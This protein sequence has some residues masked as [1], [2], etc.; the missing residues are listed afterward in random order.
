MSSN[1]RRT[2]WSLEDY[3][4]LNSIELCTPLAGHRGI[5]CEI[6]QKGPSLSQNNEIG[7]G[8]WLSPQYY[9]PSPGSSEFKYSVIKERN[10]NGGYYDLHGKL[11]GFSGND[12]LQSLCYCFQEQSDW[13]SSESR[14]S[15]S[16]G[17]EFSDSIEFVEERVPDFTESGR[18]LG[19]SQYCWSDSS[20]E[21]ERNRLDIEEGTYIDEKE[22]G[23][24]WLNEKL[25]SMF[26][27]PNKHTEAK[28]LEEGT[29]L[30]K[31][32]LNMEILVQEK[33]CRSLLVSYLSKEAEIV[34]HVLLQ[35]VLFKAS[36]LQ[37][38]AFLRAT[39][40]HPLRFWR[41]DRM[42]FPDKEPSYCRKGQHNK[43]KKDLESDD[44]GQNLVLSSSWSAG[45]TSGAGCLRL[46]R[47]SPGDYLCMKR[48]LQDLRKIEEEYLTIRGQRESS[49]N[50][51]IPD[52]NDRLDFALEDNRALSIGIKKMRIDQ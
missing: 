29:H 20:L 34:Y 2:E 7:S 46:V 22:Q 1:L 30:C 26:S 28:G 19:V 47:K 31:L 13:L 21:F 41:K 17:G 39:P 43:H 3:P 44:N 45:D 40:K 51:Q 15:S 12:D 6:E 33:K 23:I 27:E 8:D 16:A 18:F 49:E 9:S 14:N 50:P 52:F 4:G 42:D 10:N 38:R 32:Q 35:F 25:K 24:E 36:S 5:E 48:I 37:N 11:C